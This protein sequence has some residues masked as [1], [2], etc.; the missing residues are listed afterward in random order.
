M[1]LVPVRTR[2]ISSGVGPYARRLSTMDASNALDDKGVTS[3]SCNHIEPV[4]G[5]FHSYPRMAPE[6]FGARGRPRFVV[7]KRRKAS[8]PGYGVHVTFCWPLV[9]VTPVIR[10]G[11][12]FTSAA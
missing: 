1:A 5:P 3:N 9:T 12:G 10:G 7:D 11:G 8:A 4:T 6:V 2:S